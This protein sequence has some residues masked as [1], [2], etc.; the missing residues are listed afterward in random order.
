MP[1]KRFTDSQMT[2][3]VEELEGGVSASG[4]SSSEVRA[5]H[6]E[7]LA[8]PHMVHEENVSSLVAYL[9]SDEAKA[10]TGQ[11]MDESAGYRTG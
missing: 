7:K 9:A 2:L 3:V 10:I 5:E 4:Q 6:M 11:A 1:K 8:L